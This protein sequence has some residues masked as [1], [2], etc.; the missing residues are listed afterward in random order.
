MKKTARVSWK[1][2]DNNFAGELGSGYTFDISGNAGPE[3]GAGPME[4]LLAGVAGC[5]AID[6]VHI[7]R[8]QRQDVSGV[9]VEIEAE[10]ATDYPMVYTSAEVT[11]IVRGDVTE[12]AVVKAIE[13]SE[14][15]YCSA[16]IM[17]KRSGVQMHSQ[18][19]IEPALEPA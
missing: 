3:N 1:G 5:T 6:I 4:L 2:T 11:Y 12:S 15:K 16:S 18:Y 10:R 17:F 8:K 14:E 9:E 7:L 19:R 13:L